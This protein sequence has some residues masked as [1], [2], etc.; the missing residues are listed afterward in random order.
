M[1]KPNSVIRYRSKSF[2]RNV[3]FYI[4]HIVSHRLSIGEKWASQ[5]KLGGGMTLAEKK[6]LELHSRGIIAR[7]NQDYPQS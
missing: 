4:V 6:F 1:L 5:R 3:V 7:S 2:D